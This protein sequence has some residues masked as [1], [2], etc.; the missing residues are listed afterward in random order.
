MPGQKMRFETWRA[1]LK[2]HGGFLVGRVMD[3]I[4]P[5]FERHGFIWHSDYAANSVQQV[6]RS[7]LPLQM[8]QGIEWPTVE[9]QFDPRHGRNFSI[10]F[11][12]LPLECREGGRKLIAREKAVVV[13]APVWFLLCKGR[14]RSYEGQFGVGRFSLRPHACM[15]REVQEAFSLL[16]VIFAHF[17]KRDEQHWLN[18]PFGYIDKNTLLVSSWRIYLEH[19]EKQRKTARSD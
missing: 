5:E 8:R 15:E 2:K 17:E 1:R 16:S 6:S 10:L 4:V 13:N 11:A 7:T 18:Q 19:I 3:V 12:S 9:I 14:N